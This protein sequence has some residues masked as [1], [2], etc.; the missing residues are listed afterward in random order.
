MKLAAPPE[1]PSSTPSGHGKGRA[2]LAT[3]AVAIAIAVPVGIATKGSGSRSPQSGS[4]P[5]QSAPNSDSGGS[6]P[7]SAS[8]S[9]GQQ[10]ADRQSAAESAFTDAVSTKVQD[11]GA[12]A[13]GA[14]VGPVRCSTHIGI[15]YSCTAELDVNGAP[16]GSAS[17]ACD[18]QGGTDNFVC[19]VIK[20][21]TGP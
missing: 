17:G 16:A 14:S 8:P 15:E 13:G 7:A 3:L 10:A 4:Q 1:S 21:N 11:S 2:R 9:P 19:D 5:A 18:S 12:A 20:I 6:G